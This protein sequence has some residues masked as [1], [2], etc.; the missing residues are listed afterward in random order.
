MTIRVAT[1]LRLS[2]KKQALRQGKDELDIP[3][4]REAIAAF[5]KGKPD[6]VHV[7]EYQEAGVSAFKVSA[8]DRDVLQEVLRDARAGAWSILVVFKAD[9]LSRNST[10][11]PMVIARLHKAGVGV[12]SVADAP[13]GKHL[14]LDNQMEK[15]LRFLEGWQAETESVNTQIRVS[16]RMRQLAQEGRWCGSKVP[17][18][19][20]LVAEKD[21]SGEPIMRGGRPVR[22]LVPHPDY[23]A[24][25]REMF[26]RYLSGEG[27]MPIAGWMNQRAIPTYTGAPWSAQTVRE[28]L[29]NPLYAGLITY[30]RRSSLAEAPV[31]VRG[32]HEALIDLETFEKASALR[33]HKVALAPRQRTGTYALTGV[34]R[35]ASCGGS[36]GGITRRRV[37]ARGGQVERQGYRC[38][39]W[40]HR[41]T[42]ST[43]ELNG[44]KLEASFLAKL[45]ELEQPSGLRNLMEMGAK[46][47][48]E[49]L[50]VAAEARKRA[51]AQLGVI[52]QALARLDHAYLEA[53]VLT[54]EEYREKKLAYMEQKQTLEATLAAPL[55]SGPS[56]DFA[57]LAA[58]AGEL[59]A[60]WQYMTAE[61]RKV[62][63]LNLMQAHDLLIYAHPDATVELRPK[64]DDRGAETAAD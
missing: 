47:H 35:C 62:F 57:A 11:Y 45:E 63:V 1:L 33:E 17:F 36:M 48:Q 38:I 37:N 49:A 31:Q 50:R 24:V 21:P 44:A 14:G 55:P 3:A 58:L 42:C 60:N 28:I 53:A 51:E 27:H 13:G 6:W 61:E 23:G 64:G 29:T 34:L 2:T 46:E 26:R 22:K 43:V 41:R 25:V 40:A 8:D 56:V 16:G 4:Q 5:L 52:K 32:Q 9:R 18:G 54:T 30:G 15:F 7:K 59:R 20:I 39:N 10:E 19:Y 12:W